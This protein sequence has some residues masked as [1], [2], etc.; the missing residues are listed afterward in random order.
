MSLLNNE[1]MAQRW[2]D[3]SQIEGKYSGL[4]LSRVVRQDASSFAFPFHFLVQSCCDSFPTEFAP[5][6]PEHDTSELYNGQLEIMARAKRTKEAEDIEFTLR[7]VFKKHG[8]RPLQKEVITATIEGHDVFLQAA[9]SFGKSL[10][11]QLPAF[12]SS[13]I[14]VVVSPL[15]ALMMNQINASRSIG[16]PTES[17]NSSTT[18]IE[19][20]RIISDL[21]CGH[22]HTRLL[23][24]TPELCSLDH[25]RKTLKTIHQQGQLIRVAI[26][27][28]HCISEWGHDFRP[29]YKELSWLKK[30][31]ILPSVPIIALTATATPKVRVDIVKCLG[32]HPLVSPTQ[33][34]QVSDK[35]TK[36]FSTTTAR[37]NIHYE[38]RYFSEEFPRNPSGDDVF[39][40]LLCWLTSISAR[41]AQLLASDTP[42]PPSAL[43]PISGIIYVP[44][45]TKADS[46]ASQLCSHSIAALAYHAGHDSSHRTQIQEQ[47]LHPPIPPNPAS[48]SSSNPFN[49]IVATTAFGMGID[50]P[51]VRFVIHFGLPRGLES[52]VQESGRCGR[53]GKAAAS[54]VLYTREQRDR[55]RCLVEADVQRELAHK[56]PKGAGLPPSTRQAQARSKKE[57]L[58]SAISYC[59]ST[60]QCRHRIISSYFGD[61]DAPV[62]DL[63]CDFCKEGSTALRR[64]MESGLG[65]A[66][67]VYAAT[68]QGAGATQAHQADNGVDDY[69]YWSQLGG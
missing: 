35:V 42:L 51:H 21:L 58:E 47:F 23:Y 12:I 69:D 31:L 2:G 15:L 5:S 38:V 46:L 48:A 30:T 37:P 33:P 11:F 22:P 10:C 20:G 32:L 61:D 18:T 39:A 27:E 26:D 43:A 1:L 67:D 41:R 65:M 13:G 64:R 56:G 25:F 6:Q 7:R 34:S 68:Q 8:F 19:R 17:I 57:S 28:A 60:S 62:C 36:F 29:A 55:V 53:D 59:E 4:A 16:I 44:L 40:Y 24:V 54:V 14:T 63:A 45:R 9:T 52:F 66:E 50:A 3:C 49:I